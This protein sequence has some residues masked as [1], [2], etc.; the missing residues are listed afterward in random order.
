MEVMDASLWK[1]SGEFFCGVMSGKYP[2]SEV[3]EKRTRG[4]NKK[5]IFG[6]L[7]IMVAETRDGREGAL[8][9]IKQTGGGG[10]VMEHPG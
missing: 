5:N 3:V 10:Y 1:W 7:Y 9:Y 8:P 2:N 6:G 4:T